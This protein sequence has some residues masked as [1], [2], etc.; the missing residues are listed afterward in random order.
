MTRDLTPTAFFDLGDCQFADLFDG[1][2]FVWQA[3]AQIDSY[4]KNKIG[5]AGHRIEATV[6]DGAFIAEGDVVIGPGTVIE[7]GA[8]IAGP[9]FIGAHCQIRQGAYIR[10]NALIGDGC[11]VGHSSEIKNAVLLS[12]AGAPHFNYVG[13][14]ILGCDVNLGAGTKLSNLTVLSAK[15]P[16]TGKRP[17]IHLTIDGQLYDTD[18]AKFGAIIGDSAQTG[19]NTVLNPGVLLGP[20]TLVYANTS[21]PKG[22]YPS[23]SI[24]KLRQT[25]EISVSRVVG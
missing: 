11:V 16:K 5:G 4:L 7:P 12:G 17:T 9:A 1:L 3:I 15:D 24:I 13:D 6:M 20:R 21:L 23:D 18:L 2:E 14:S 8:Y 22:Y 25:I 19:C 10:G